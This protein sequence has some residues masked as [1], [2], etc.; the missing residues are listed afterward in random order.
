M[1][2]VDSS[3]WIKAGRR[4][5]PLEVKIALESLL[6]AYEACWCSVVKLEVLGWVRAEKRAK[7]EFFFST[8]PYKIVSEP[9]WES[10]K[11]L[12]W[13]LRDSGLTVPGND[14]LL[15]ALAIEQGCRLYS[16]DHHFVEIAERIPALMLY[17]PGYGGQYDPEQT[18]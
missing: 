15:A 13:K 7:L 5:G 2:L 10:A 11:K 18:E 14:V 12:C 16:V 9:I 8:I 3:V 17:K 4:D 6:E 1:I